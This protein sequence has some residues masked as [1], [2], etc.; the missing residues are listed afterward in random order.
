MS[1][2][3]VEVLVPEGRGPGDVPEHGEGVGGVGAGP[4]H[5]PGHAHRGEVGGEVIG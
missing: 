5:P 1:G 2:S 3:E 4:R